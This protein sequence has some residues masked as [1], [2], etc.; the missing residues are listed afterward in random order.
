MAVQIYINYDGICEEAVNYYAEVFEQP[1]PVFTR[2][3]DQP[4]PDYPLTKEAGNRIMHT[5][6]KIEGDTI[7]FSDVF[8]GMELIVG[9]N[10][11]LTVVSKDIEHTRRHFQRLKEGGE[12]KVELQETFWSPLYGNLADRYGINWQFSTEPK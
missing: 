6:L 8:P 12:V 3:K 7:M 11:S 10:L 1:V 5:E 2:F 4:S 9:N